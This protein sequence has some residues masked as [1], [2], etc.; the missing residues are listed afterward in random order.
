MTTPSWFKREIRH[1]DVGPD[2]VCVKRILGLDWETPWDTSA[3]V[4]LR[5]YYGTG[6]VTAE[7]AEKIGERAADAAGLAPEWYYRD[8]TVG[9]YGDDVDAVRKLIGLE[10]G[11]FCPRMRDAVKRYE[12]T[13]G[14]NPT[15][16]V[17]LELARML[18]EA[19][20]TAPSQFA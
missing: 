15:G 16:I 7:V 13:H 14:R 11:V 8:L 2:V 10:A 18:G 20:G 19:L 17:D 1:G 12:G 3:E 9:D 5:G 4:L 6:V